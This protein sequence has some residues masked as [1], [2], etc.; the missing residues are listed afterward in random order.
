[1][2]GP[3][4]IFAAPLWLEVGPQLWPT[5]KAKRVRNRVDTRRQGLLESILEVFLPENDRKKQN[6]RT[7]RISKDAVDSEPTTMELAE[8]VVMPPN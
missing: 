6:Q 5:L 4:I 3:P 7:T 1:M 2:E 8:I